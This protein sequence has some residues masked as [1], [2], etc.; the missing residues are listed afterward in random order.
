VHPLLLYQVKIMER[1]LAGL[2]VVLVLILIWLNR[3][4]TYTDA[5]ITSLDSFFKDRYRGVNADNLR[6]YIVKTILGVDIS[7][8]PSI[9]LSNVNLLVD[10]LNSSGFTFTRFSDINELNTMFETA[11]TSGESGLGNRDRMILRTF[12]WPGTEI[13]REFSRVIP[14]NYTS[15]GVTDF[16]STIV[17]ESGKTTKEMLQYCFVLVEK[18]VS[19]DPTT[20]NPWTPEV[21][22]YINSTIPSKYTPKF[23]RTDTN[24]IQNVLES[25]TP[26][27]TTIWFIKALMIGPAYLAWLAENKWKLDLTWS[28]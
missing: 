26:N 21:I 15:D 4:E 20:G 2:I 16:T 22:D 17:S 28:P 27:E 9:G 24:F 8:D 7:D 3:R 23:D 6:K 12:A 5:Q 13:T 19:G 10:T 11:Y 25:P 1:V 14:V 18:L